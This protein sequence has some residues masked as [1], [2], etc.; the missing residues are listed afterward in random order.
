MNFKYA[1]MAFGAAVMCFGVC[2]C[3]KSDRSLITTLEQS[4]R[5][6]I[7]NSNQV[8]KVSDVTDFKW[9]KL[10]IFQPY[11][12]I[13]RI[14]SRLGFRWIDPERVT[15]SVPETAYLLVFVKDGQVVRRIEFP[16]SV[17]DFSSLEAQEAFIYG[18]D[19]FDVKFVQTDTA[20]RLCF[21]ARP[22]K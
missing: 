16:R 21:V 7:T 4:A 11:T 9:D 12:P 14:N 10:F 22:Q 3:A 15:L 1:L 13:D 8:V 2:G 20:N 5:A 6:A 17:G 18:R 19:I